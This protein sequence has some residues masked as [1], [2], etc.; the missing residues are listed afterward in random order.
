MVSDTD[1]DPCGINLTN[2]VIKIFF[3][4]VILNLKFAIWML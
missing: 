1:C 4:G 2:G 3:L